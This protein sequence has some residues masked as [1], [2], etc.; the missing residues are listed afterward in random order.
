MVE[1]FLQEYSLSTPLTLAFP[2]PV[3]KFDSLSRFLPHIVWFCHSN[4][5]DGEYGSHMLGRNRNKL[6]PI[7]SSAEQWRR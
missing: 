5:A 6:K 1:E 3:T 7:I 4:L 2:V